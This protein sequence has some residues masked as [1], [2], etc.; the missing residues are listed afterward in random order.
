MSDWKDKLKQVKENLTKQPEKKTAGKPSNPVASVKLPSDGMTAM[1]IP[2]EKLFLKTMELDG[3]KPIPEFIAMKPEYGTA[4]RVVLKLK[5]LTASQSV[6][7]GSKHYQPGLQTKNIKSDSAT[8]WKAV[9]SELPSEIAGGKNRVT[10]GID[11]GTSTTKVCARLELGENDVPIYRLD[12]SDNSDKLGGLTPSLVSM[13]EGVLYFGDHAHKGITIPHVKVCLACEEKRFST[14]ECLWA[15]ACPI[16]TSESGLSASDL[17]TLYLSWVMKESRKRLPEPLKKADSFVF[18]IGIPL[19]QLDDSPLKAVFDQ[20][21]YFAWRLSN[22]VM[23]GLSIAQAKVWLG[24]LKKQGTTIPPPEDRMIQLCPET[25]AA[26]V[27]FV[28]S[29]KALPGLYCLCD[30]GAWTSDISV[31]RL[32][33][34]AKHETGVDRLSFYASGV[35]RKACEEIDLRIV[36]CLADL[37]GL[38][39]INDFLD[40]DITREIRSVREGQQVS[41]IFTVFT[42]NGLQR[43]RGLPPI[44][45]DYARNVVAE[46]VGRY[47]VKIIK[48]AYQEKER[49]PD[50]WR[51]VS[52]LMT[53]GGSRDDIFEEVFSENCGFQFSKVLLSMDTIQN[54]D[55]KQHFRFAVAAGLSHPLAIWPEQLLPS[56]VSA[57]RPQAPK[58]IA[59]RDEQYAK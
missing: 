13:H 32:T 46:A 5:D 25:S 58:K 51:D 11:F 41:A 52:L 31:F 21:T 19:K 37:W 28:N 20:I 59:D 47:F 55:K 18:N 16:S 23:Q 7:R 17:A 53:G 4:K 48:Q 34:V 40:D 42:E 36:N 15:D 12:I 56:E 6:H 2:D 27:S 1:P 26:I 9:S 50:N 8:A 38:D 14:K 54:A 30:I 49:N 3:V 43:E 57:W 10:I 33:D 35:T 29:A 39:S 45:R 24:I 22:G 44:A